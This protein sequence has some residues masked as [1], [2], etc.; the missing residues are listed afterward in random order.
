MKNIIRIFLTLL[1]PILSSAQNTDIK[2]VYPLSM[3]E[4]ELGHYENAAEKFQIIVDNYKFDDISTTKLYNG[5]CIFA[6]AKHNKTAITILDYLASNRFYSNYEHIISDTDLSN[7]HSDTEWN[8][9]I[10]K[11][12]E[13]RKT[14]PKRLQEKIKSELS[15]AKEILLADNGKLWGENIWS[16]NILVLDFDNT[17]YTIK[18]LPD[19]KTDDS[20]IYYKKIPN[21]TLSLSNSAQEYNGEQYAVILTNYLDD[22]SATIIHELFHI[23]QYKHIRLNGNPIQYLDNYDARE[24]L[25]LEYQ[26]L[27]NALNS[28]N[29][30]KNKLEIEKYVNDAFLFREL[31]QSKYK[32]YL[33]DEIEIETSEGLANYTGFVLSTYSNK[34]EKTISEINQRE[35][36]QTYT[37]PFPY[38]TGPAYG[39]IFDYLKIDWKIG[40]DTTYNYLN[41]YE[42]KYLK[43]KIKASNG[44]IKSAQQRNNYK[45]IHKQELDKKIEN[46]KVI[47]YY[48]DIFFKK[49]SLTVKLIDSLY[50]LTFDM[51]G[52]IIL[53]D[54]GIVYSMV[55]GVDGSKNNFGNFSTIKGKEKLGISGVLMSFVEKKYTFPL[56]IKIEKNKIIGEYYIIELSEGWEVIKVNE[57]GDMEIV[58]KKK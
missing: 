47:S 5:V 10:E 51:N 18:P 17:I 11:V 22:N 32:E 8:K 31:R 52:T 19:S 54:K 12:S 26:A 24:W 7:I 13:N 27:K 34:Y 53:K 49:P 39:L 4:Y 42:Q 35:Q 44:K 15:K 2:I 50:G 40:L 46:E 48:T 55:E 3:K 14:Q 23:L 56:P 45:E 57:K 9:I 30:N 6:L 58:K 16:E 33:Q 29:Q 21:N 43:K 25:R 38:A 1:F 37:R 36:A 41:I 28:I 20:I